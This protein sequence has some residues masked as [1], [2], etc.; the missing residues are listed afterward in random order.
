MRW[1]LAC[2]VRLD[3]PPQNELESCAVP[4]PRVVLS[5]FLKMAGRRSIFGICCLLFFPNSL[6]A[7]EPP[8]AD[9]LGCHLEMS[10]MSHP[11]NILPPFSGERLPMAPDGTMTCTTCH[12]GDLH[13]T[14]V[15]E[16]PD[17]AES[18][19]HCHESGGHGSQP[20]LVHLVRLN[21]WSRPVLTTHSAA[22]AA[23]H[24]G[25]VVS[26]RID[27]IDPQASRRGFSALAWRRAGNHPV[28]GD[29]QTA[30][31]TQRGKY[32]SCDDLPPQILFEED[33]IGCGTCHDIY[34][35]RAFHL[36]V[37]HDGRTLCVACHAMNEPLPPIVADDRYVTLRLASRS[38]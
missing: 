25:Q 18:C 36:L 31:Q 38:D 5:W 14:S 1:P 28:G 26:E 23:C 29:Y 27:R 37:D 7:G 12:Q 16:R 8:P 24:A 10:V 21:K 9:C 22:C 35:G 19:T 34:G 33:S 4:K 15:A 2:S 32:R 30:V 13:A 11:V 20:W 6:W 17:P 3:S